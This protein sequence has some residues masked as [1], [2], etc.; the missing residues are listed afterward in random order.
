MLV[1]GGVDLPKTTETKV[2]LDV[3]YGVIQ[4]IAHLTGSIF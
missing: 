2:R 1:A 3:T 4:V